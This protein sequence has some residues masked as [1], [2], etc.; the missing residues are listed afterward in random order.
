MTAF[1]A[2]ARSH[3]PEYMDDDATDYATFR[4]CLVDLARVNRLSLGYRPT[5]AFLERLR[6]D[7]RLPSGRPVSI[8]D[9]GCGYGDTLR[10]V[11][12]WAQRVGAAVALVGVDRN[13]W[14]ERAAREATPVSAPIDYRTVD[15]F[16]F[17][18]DGP[19]DVVLSALFT[20]HLA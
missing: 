4:G 11:A 15:L 2:V 3:E 12:T 5:I 20:H 6:K 19:V 16:D 1:S 8:V 10:A 7:G 14:A 17:K 9:A 13:P 18:P